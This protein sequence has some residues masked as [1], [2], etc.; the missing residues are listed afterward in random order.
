MAN[1]QLSPDEIE[2]AK[3]MIVEQ[4]ENL[5]ID[6]KL[7]AYH[8]D[9]EKGISEGRIQIIDPM[10]EPELTKENCTPELWEMLGGDSLKDIKDEDLPF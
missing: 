2:A 7:T 5:K 1:E 8:E 6:P 4:L 9:M 10:D 3:K